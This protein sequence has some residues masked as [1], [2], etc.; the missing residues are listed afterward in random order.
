MN[1]MKPKTLKQRLAA[2]EEALARKTKQLDTAATSNFELRMSLQSERQLVNALRNE[3]DEM[4]PADRHEAVEKDLEKTRRSLAESEFAVGELRE[5]NKKQRHKLEGRLAE[6]DGLSR[7]RYK[8]IEKISSELEAT[9]EQYTALLEEHEKLKGERPVTIGDVHR[10][11][12]RADNACEDLDHLQMELEQKKEEMRA[13]TNEIESLKSD[14]DL[15]LEQLFVERIPLLRDEL[16][17]LRS[18]L[19]QAKEG[20][21][22]E[23]LRA[24]NARRDADRLHEALVSLRAA[25]NE[26][27]AERAALEKRLEEEKERA[28]EVETLRAEL[29]SERE[30]RDSLRYAQE[31]LCKGKPSDNNKI[32][33][34][35]GALEE[36]RKNA[37]RSDQL[38]RDLE[39]ARENVKGWTNRAHSAEERIRFRENEMSIEYGEL[40]ERLE[41]AEE[42]LKKVVAK[43][44]TLRAELDRALPRLRELEKERLLFLSQIE[45]LTTRANTLQGEILQRD[46]GIKHL[47][48]EQEALLAKNEALSKRTEFLQEKGEEREKG[49]KEACALARENT[50]KLNEAEGSLRRLREEFEAC[51]EALSREQRR[52]HEIGILTDKL[53]DYVRSCA[54]N[55]TEE[56]EG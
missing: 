42:E 26:S 50:I 20:V 23:K 15:A 40:R 29:H 49:Y 10:E 44:D 1:H 32:L 30:T 53:A 7:A 33:R 18:K 56:G 54:G 55:G 39:I 45:A 28:N 25:A 27:L 17:G 19:A 6:I 9:K 21:A 37:R 41:R 46:R 51:R 31:I 22:K 43:R 52:T 35:E 38:Q 48:R 47:E 5:I 12:L 2:A 14:Q 36:A 16:I 8:Q 4:I 11:K 13:L 34:L 24:D 3:L